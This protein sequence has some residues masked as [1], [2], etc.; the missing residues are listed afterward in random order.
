MPGHRRGY[1]ALG[2][3]LFQEGVTAGCGVWKKSQ[4]QKTT[5]QYPFFV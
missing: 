5:G 1:L 2:G 4:A 3:S